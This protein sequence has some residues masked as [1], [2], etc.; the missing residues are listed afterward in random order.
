MLVVDHINKIGAF[1]A[2]VA[3]I[4]VRFAENGNSVSPW[5]L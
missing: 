5:T 4:A 1:A 3:G 2:A